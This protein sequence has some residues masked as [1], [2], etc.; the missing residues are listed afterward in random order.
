GGSMREIALGYAVRFGQPAATA[1]ADPLKFARASGRNSRLIGPTRL[2]GQ[3]ELDLAASRPR[4]L[5]GGFVDFLLGRGAHGR[6]S[7]ARDR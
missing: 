5:P 7:I 6:R 4:Q 2:R 3:L 1:I